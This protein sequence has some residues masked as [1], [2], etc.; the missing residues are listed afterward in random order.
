MTDL[1][2]NEIDEVMTGIGMRVANQVVGKSLQD[3]DVD[4]LLVSALQK[5]SE[6]QLYEAVDNM[7]DLLSISEILNQALSNDRKL[8]DQELAEFKEYLCELESDTKS[9]MKSLLN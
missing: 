1:T 4:D 7:I 2:N 9:L 3:D 5:A 8:D 6:P